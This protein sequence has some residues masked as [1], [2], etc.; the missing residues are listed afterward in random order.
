[1]KHNL[2]W[3]FWLALISAIVG[4]LLTSVIL[5]KQ[6]SIFES[7]SDT[8]GR[9]SYPLENL[10]KDLEDALN[11]KS[12][13]EILLLRS[14]ITEYGE[15]YLIDSKGVDML[16]RTLP[17]E[18]STLKNQSEVIY[19]RLTRRIITNQGEIFSLIY[20]HNK[21]TPLFLWTLFKK[22]GLYWVL[23]A[24]L[25]VSS[26]ISWWLAMKTVRPIQDIALA[27]SKHGEGN[28]LTKIDSK[29]IQ[30]N[31]EIGKLARQLKTSGLK[32]N[33]LLKKQ[34]DFLRDVS[35]EVRA[36]LARLQLACETLE[37][38]ATDKRSLN[39]IKEEVVVIDQLVQDL[40]HL[41][42][43][44]RPSLPH[45]FEDILIS[46]L[47]D[48]CVKRSKILTT[49]KGLTITI[50]QNIAQKTTIR[51]IK[52]LLDRALDNLINNAVRYSPNNSKIEIKCEI[53]EEYCNLGIW[54]QGEGV[55]EKS[56]QDI[57]EP[58]FR[59]DSSRNRQT[60]G[61][62]LG[63]SLVKRILEFHNGSVIASNHPN[64]FFVVLS[65]PLSK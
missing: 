3:T 15:A 5:M 63:L 1:M 36:P 22:F 48:D 35:H 21:Q 20:Y 52:F 47:V 9:P 43:F 44:D 51:G 42:Y 17:E 50:K 57:F 55:N 62:G 19:P 33:D 45:K 25:A 28:F 64:G 59:L 24:A 16:G 7:Y 58:F 23:L 34:K 2:V 41:S 38:D 53:Q 12:D 30:R 32:I 26:L 54:D 11:N 39:Q 8:G 46:T 6:W 4:T 49:S 56:L 29:I 61:F 14:P 27:I 13:I 65:I 60:G 40:L 10:S 31:D 18:I 37:I